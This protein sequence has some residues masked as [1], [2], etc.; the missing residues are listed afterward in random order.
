MRILLA[1]DSFK[2][3]RFRLQAMAESMRSG[4]ERPAIRRRRMP[5]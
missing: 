4:R 1:P 3:A 5:A 2:E